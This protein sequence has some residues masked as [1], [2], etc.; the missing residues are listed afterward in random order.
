MKKLVCLFLFL[1][2]ITPL[3]AQ[4][5]ISVPWS[6]SFDCDD[7]QQDGDP[8]PCPSEMS[9]GNQ[10]YYCT[11]DGDIYSRI[12][13]TWNNPIG[14]GSRGFAVSW[15]DAE[16]TSGNN[17]ATP[18]FTFSPQ[19]SELYIRFYIKYPT[20]WTWSSGSFLKKILYIGTAAYANKAYLVYYGANKIALY[21]QQGGGMMWHQ[22]DH[23]TCAMPSSYPD[24]GWNQLMAGEENNAYGQKYGDGEWHYIEV[25][26]KSNTSS[27]P[28]N[29]VYELWVDGTVRD[30]HTEVEWDQS[31]FSQID[32]MAN[33]TYTD[34]GGCT[35]F[36]IDD[37]GISTT[38]IGA[39]EVDS[40][41][42]SVTIFQSDPTTIQSVS[43]TLTGTATDGVGVSSCKWRPDAA[44]DDSNGT[45][46][47]GSTSW[48]CAVTGMALGNNTVY[49][50]CT[51]AAG[52]WGSDS[53]TVT[54]E[55]A[56]VTGRVSGGTISGGVM[57]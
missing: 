3:Q 27:S 54:R 56:A 51:D 15:G 2:L 49:V 32:M 30:Q 20:T 28:A 13:T 34:N 53:L 25:H 42:P 38:Y 37:I 48:S 21:I 18:M 5:T 8:I 11:G 46:C 40:T 52:N 4:S 43:I 26:L 44:P 23:T 16:G 7:W 10:I 57:Q 19:P 22:Q 1:L 31:T 45:A 47:S 36:G 33:G 39:I 12:S 29:G 41:A 17:A 24:W 14:S 6:T 50:G 55:V 9:L 35:Y